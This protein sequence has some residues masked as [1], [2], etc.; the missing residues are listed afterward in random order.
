[1]VATVSLSS[2]FDARRLWHGR[3][4]PAAAD[5]V[6]TGLAALDDALPQG[7]WP[8]AALT[9]ILLPRD[10]IGE[11]QLLLPSLAALTGQRRHVALIAPPYVPCV[12]GWVGAGLDMRQVDIVEA[13]TAD[14]L[15]AMEQCLRSASYAAVLGWPAQADDR[16]LRRLQIAAD[17]G[18]TLAFV[19]RDCRHAGHASPATLRIELAS[20][21]TRQLRVR[22]C[23]G[24]QPPAHALS[25]PLQAYG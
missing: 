9:E 20:G 15:W 5:G 2:L 16:A 24:G 1:M 14:A 6:P 10:G 25:L 18:Q 22:K 23:R 7:G 12:A 8:P 21:G 19:F 4:Q 11:L 13:G 3:A 17:T